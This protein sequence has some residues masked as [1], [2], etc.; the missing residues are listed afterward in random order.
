MNNFLEL[1]NEYLRIKIDTLFGG[2]IV[3]I[4]DKIKTVNWVWLNV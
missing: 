1:E 2:K 3:E 4:F